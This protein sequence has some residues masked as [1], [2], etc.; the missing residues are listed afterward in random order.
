MEANENCMQRVQIMFEGQAETDVGSTQPIYQTLCTKAAQS[1]KT[2]NNI[3]VTS[4]ITDG[5]GIRFLEDISVKFNL[6]KVPL[7]LQDLC[8]QLQWLSGD[9]THESDYRPRLQ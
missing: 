5:A 8:C 3:T 1:K 7:L 2:N 6:T 4:H 9:T